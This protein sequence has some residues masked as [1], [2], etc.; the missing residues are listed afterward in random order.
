MHTFRVHPGILANVQV[1]FWTPVVCFVFVLLTVVFTVD[2]L[3]T[4]FWVDPNF[5]VVAGIFLGLFLYLAIYYVFF[6]TYSITL[7]DDRVLIQYLGFR[8]IHIPNHAVTRLVKKKPFAKKRTYHFFWGDYDF[9][10]EYEIHGKKRKAR[11]RDHMEDQSVLLHELHTRFHDR[12]RV[13][14]DRDW[15]NPISKAPVSWRV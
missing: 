11:F 5:Y 10:I 4:V 6:K 3:E 14:I 12:P 15:W 7:L 8:T 2:T 9:Y 1:A 13:F